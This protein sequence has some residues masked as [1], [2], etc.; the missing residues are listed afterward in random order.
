MNMVRELRVKKGIQAKQLALDIGV[1]NATVSDWEHG[2]K[3]PTGERLKKL[4]EY[5]GV[6]E[7]FV[8]G[9]GMD[10]HDNLFVPEDP[11]SCGKSE[12]EQIIERLLERL[13]PKT[14]EARIL[15][16]GI[17]KLPQE[18]REQALNVVRAMFSQHADYFEGGGDDA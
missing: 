7:G 16:T 3:N 6:D 15:A 13:Q 2:R 17:D 12:T 4:A 18:Q 9:Y 1:S 5:F 11:A 14:P 8:L 10:K